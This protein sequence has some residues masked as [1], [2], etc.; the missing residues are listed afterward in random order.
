MADP[1]LGRFRLRRGS[2]L[3]TKHKVDGIN[4]QDFVDTNVFALGDQQFVTGIVCDGCS[5]AGDPKG[6]RNE[7]GAV[8]LG[9]FALSEMELLIRAQV[10]IEEIPNALYP[11]CHSY[12]GTILRL[13]VVGDPAK[14]WKFIERHLLATVVGFI[15]DRE[16]AVIFRAGDGVIIVDDRVEI[17][18]QDGPPEYL[19]YHLVDR[20]ILEQHLKD[21]QL[22][23]TF[24]SGVIPLAGIKRLAIASDGLAD[25]K[26]PTG[27][28]PEDLSGIF[29][30]QPKAPCGLQWHLN[31]RTNFGRGFK[32]DCSIVTLAE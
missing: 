4:N 12:L 27:V 2:T 19:A 16:K 17:V 3:G 14:Q 10:P 24:R 13:S 28:R 30:H 23:Q 9:N 29:E 25:L 6:S 11:R 7:V 5:V 22:P 8:L 20:Q 31:K 32:D 18:T 26:D 15:A 1:L 21:M